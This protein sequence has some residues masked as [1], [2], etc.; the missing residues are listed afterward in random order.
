MLLEALNE[1]KIYNGGK[2][3]NC[4]IKFLPVAFVDG[5]PTVIFEKHVGFF[6]LNLW[7]RSVRPIPY[8]RHPYYGINIGSANSINKENETIKNIFG[9]QSGLVYELND[10]TEHLNVKNY[11]VSSSYFYEMSGLDISLSE[12]ISFVSDQWDDFSQ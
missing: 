12:V 9:I 2:F 1:R 3:G 4:R 5:T 8:V 6:S 7:V 11:R 10:L